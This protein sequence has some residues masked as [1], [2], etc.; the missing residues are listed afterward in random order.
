MHPL[1]Q[2]EEFG[3]NLLESCSFLHDGVDMNDTL[4]RDGEVFTLLRLGIVDIFLLN[5]DKVIRPELSA[6]NGLPS[7]LNEFDGSG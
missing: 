1:S 6:S 4:S 5:L 2:S 7:A 3:G